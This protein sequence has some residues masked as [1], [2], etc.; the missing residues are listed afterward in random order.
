MP[1]GSTSRTAHRRRSGTSV[2]STSQAAPTPSTAQR[3]VQAT[4]SRTRVPQQ[5]RDRV[6][7]QQPLRP[8]PS[9]EC[10]A[11]TT[12]KASG[13]RTAP[14]GDRTAGG[15]H[16][17]PATAARPA[18]GQGAGDDLL[19]GGNVLMAPALEQSQPLLHRE[20]FAAVAELGGGQGVRVEVG[21]AGCRPAAGADPRPQRVLVAVAVGEDFLAFLADQER[22]KLLRRGLVGARLQD[23]GARRRRRGRRGRRRRSSAVRSECTW[24]P[25]SLRRRY[26]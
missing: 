3:S 19:G 5:H 17:R 6:A 7:K 23:R 10:W 24:T 13:S 18:C 25:S 15:A 26:Q 11:S 20:G 14:G 2:R 22:E 8:R 9:P 12:R 4:A 21:P 1:S 16:Q